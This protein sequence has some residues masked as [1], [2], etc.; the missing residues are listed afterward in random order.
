MLKGV[1]PGQPLRLSVVRAG[2]RQNLYLDSGAKGGVDGVPG[3]VAAAMTTLPPSTMGQMMVPRSPGGGQND[4][5]LPA[6]QGAANAPAPLKTEFEWMGMEL[7]PISPAMK[8]KNRALLGKFGAMVADVDPG[9]QAE[10]AGIQVGDIVTAI[11][12]WQVPSA[13]ALEQAITAA[14]TQKGILLQVERDNTRM[15]ATLP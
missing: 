4:V 11:N 2:Q 15:F 14:G 1:I 12:N 10:M 6:G 8:A 13:G 3:T 9:T 7:T 5:R